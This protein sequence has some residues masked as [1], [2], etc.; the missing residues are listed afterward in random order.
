M[1]YFEGQKG[2]FSMS[3]NTYVIESSIPKILYVWPLWAGLLILLLL[4]ICVY[5]FRAQKADRKLKEYGTLSGYNAAEAFT[6]LFHISE[7]PYKL[8]DIYTGKSNVY[9]PLQHAIVLQKD[10]CSEKSMR[11]IAC[12]ISVFFSLNLYYEN[13]SKWKA[14][15]FLQNKS[16]SCVMKCGIVLEVIGLGVGTMF[17]STVAFIL[18]VTDV[19][20]ASVFC[21]LIIQSLA[22]R[23]TFRKYKDL[24]VLSMLLDESEAEK[25][26]DF[27]WRCAIYL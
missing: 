9:V 11:S 18:P 23:K 21:I 25:L 16:V 8:P 24:A 19:F 20:L 17:G 27:A 13:E 5:I 1:R 15:N 22:A 2:E 3:L 6:V 12:A 4:G 7:L 26:C 10:V 14:R